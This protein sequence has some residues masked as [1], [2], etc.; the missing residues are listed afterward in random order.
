MRK[1]KIKFKVKEPKFKYFLSNVD[2][3]ENKFL[4][5]QGSEIELFF[6]FNR[7][8]QIK[9]CAFVRFIGLDFDF[10]QKLNS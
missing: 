4:D 9:M 8:V 7:L 3:N 5:W 2:K 1:I 6:F 10:A